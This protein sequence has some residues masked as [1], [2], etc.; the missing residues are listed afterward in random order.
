M[1]MILRK[2]AS[3]RKPRAAITPATIPGGPPNSAPVGFCAI[4]ISVEK[5]KKTISG[6]LILKEYYEIV[7]ESPPSNRILPHRCYRKYCSCS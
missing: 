1:A 5:K 7:N 3:S 2:R 6:R 4:D